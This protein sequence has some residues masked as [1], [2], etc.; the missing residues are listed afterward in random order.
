MF[1]AR[2]FFEWHKMM[3]VLRAVKLF[4]AQGL[5]LA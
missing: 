5:R 2:F 1:I 3:L 4:A